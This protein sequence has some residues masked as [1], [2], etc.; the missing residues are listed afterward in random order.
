MVVSEKKTDC[1]E[2]RKKNQRELHSWTWNQMKKWGMKICRYYRCELCLTK[3]H[4]VDFYCKLIQNEKRG[5]VWNIILIHHSP[6][7]LQP[8]L[9]GT[10]DGCSP[11]TGKWVLKVWR[12]TSISPPA[13]GLW[14]ARGLPKRVN[15]GSRRQKNVWVTVLG[16]LK[17]C[18]LYTNGCCFERLEKSQI[19]KKW[20]TRRTQVRPPVRPWAQIVCPSIMH[21]RQLNNDFH[22]WDSNHH[23]WHSHDLRGRILLN[24][25]LTAVNTNMSILI[26]TKLGL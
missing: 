8:C 20:L 10:H 19:T 1:C 26:F 18:T 25:R 13:A 6:N 24:G 7:P 12:R 22:K 2:N 9:Y 14:L 16:L 23:F 15:C 21:H 4:V 3:K 5:V 11:Y 17:H